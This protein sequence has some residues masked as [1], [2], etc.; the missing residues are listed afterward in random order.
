MVAE[1]TKYEGKR[2]KK[3]EKGKREKDVLVD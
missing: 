2:K 1:L 3:K